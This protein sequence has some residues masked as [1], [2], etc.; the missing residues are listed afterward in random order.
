MDREQT[1]TEMCRNYRSDYDINKDPNDPSW[2]LGLTP[3]DR[4][5]LR[6]T[7]ASILDDMMKFKDTK[8]EAR[9]SETKRKRRNRR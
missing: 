8:N 2:I 6:R 9:P 4:L 5:M 3:W 1:I 7:M